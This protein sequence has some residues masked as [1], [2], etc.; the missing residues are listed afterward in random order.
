MNISELLFMKYRGRKSS[1]YGVLLEINA[2]NL[3]FRTFRFSR[4]GEYAKTG[5][6]FYLDLKNTKE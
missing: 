3:N 4:F 6:S 5:F 1:H 2:P